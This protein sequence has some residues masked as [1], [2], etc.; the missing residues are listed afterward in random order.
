MQVHTKD[1]FHRAFPAA[2]GEI[3]TAF[4]PY[5]VCP[6]GAHVDHQYG[7]ITGFAIDKGVT[8]YYQPTEDGLVDVVSTDFPDRARFLVHQEIPDRSG[9][10]G[11]YLRG[12]AWALKL[13]QPLH[14][15]VRGVI[16]GSLPIGGLS[17]SAAV[18]LCYLQ[19]LMRVNQ[20]SLDP[21]TLIDTAYQ[22]EFGYVG[23]N[24]GKLDPA[25]EVLSRRNHLLFLDTKDDQFE[26]IPFHPDMPDFQIVV[27]YSGLSRKLGSSFNNRVDELKA[28]SWYLKALNGMELGS[29]TESRLRDID[30]EVYWHFEMTLPEPFRRRARH[31]YTECDRARRGAEAFRRGDIRTYGQLSYESGHSSIHN[32]E[33]G[34][35]HLIELYDAIV[36]APG[37]YGGRFSG[38]GFKGCLMALVDPGQ[39]EDCVEFVSRRYLDRFPDLKNQYSVHLCATEDGTG[40]SLQ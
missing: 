32:Y 9:D 10:W 3:Y 8:F 31:F 14:R 4:T 16:C 17:S 18:I 28:A 22:G 36:D 39:L 13:R 34:S 1:E 23:V 2:K 35:E 20:V 33:T 24:V 38:A 19:A 11:D 7:L 5:R 25:C 26:C 37:V 6:I 21:M 27:F 40:V 12:S 29:L 30:P 15:G